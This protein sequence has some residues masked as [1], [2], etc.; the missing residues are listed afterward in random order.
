MKTDFIPRTDEMFSS[1]QRDLMLLV[2]LNAL[3]WNI[4]GAVL[5]NLQ[6]LQTA[7]QNAWSA[8]RN[9]QNRTSAQVQAKDAARDVY[10]HAL[11]AFI[12]E[13]L[14]NNSSVTDEQRVQLQIPVHDNIR[15]RVAVP[16]GYPTVSVDGMSHLSHTLRITDP[17]NPHTQAKPDGVEKTEVQQFL[18]TVAPTPAS[19]WVH[20]ATTG[21]FLCTVSFIDADIGKTA[22]YR[23]RW[24]NT[25]G[26]AGPWSVTVSAVVA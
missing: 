5:I 11:R 6:T 13:F 10:E 7:W 23:C 19:V 4:P 2:V 3:L 24:L 15:T 14:A 21:R 22:W 25:R 20:A 26:E 8:A 12:K 16:S 18:G 1:W 17:E 9:K